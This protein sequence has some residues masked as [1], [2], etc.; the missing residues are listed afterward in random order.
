MNTRFYVNVTCF[1]RYWP[2]W[3][4]WNPLVCGDRR[5]I[6]TLLRG[7]GWCDRVESRGLATRRRRQRVIAAEAGTV[8]PSAL[9]CREES[10]RAED[11]KFHRMWTV[12]AVEKFPKRPQF[13]TIQNFVILEGGNWNGASVNNSSNDKSK[14]MNKKSTGASWRERK[15]SKFEISP[16]LSSKNQP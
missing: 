10:P 1:P 7:A 8:R 4:L 16:S 13:N 15:F 14:Y 2:L 11:K 12:I 5:A 3:W 6:V 9:Q